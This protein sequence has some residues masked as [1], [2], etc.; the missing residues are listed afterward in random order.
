MDLSKNVSRGCPMSMSK[1]WM[2]K[3]WKSRLISTSSWCNVTLCT[4]PNPCLISFGVLRVLAVGVRGCVPKQEDA[5]ECDIMLAPTVGLYKTS[6]QFL[7]SLQRM[8][9]D[10][11][12]IWITS[13]ES[14]PSSTHSELRIAVNSLMDSLRKVSSRGSLGV[15]GIGGRAWHW[16]FEVFP[17]SSNNSSS[18]DGRSMDSSISGFGSGEGLSKVLAGSADA[19]ET[20]SFYPLVTGSWALPVVGKQR[21]RWDTM[22]NR[23]VHT[24]LPNSPF[25]F[26]T[27]WVYHCFAFLLRENENNFHRKLSSDM[28]AMVRHAQSCSNSRTWLYGLLYSKPKR[29]GPEPWLYSQGRAYTRKLWLASR[30]GSPFGA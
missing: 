20:S 24:L 17:K 2:S 27:F 12:R 5:K 28:P 15:T 26:P 16:Y 1:S 19:E 23:S 4:I 6:T 25:T 10:G 18:K 13:E 21:E 3:I 7:W 14:S 9:E 8:V 22:W 29:L 11:A 30:I